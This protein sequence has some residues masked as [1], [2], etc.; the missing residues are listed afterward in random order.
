MSE[1]TLRRSSLS[2]ARITFP[3]NDEGS[4]ENYSIARKKK[5][6]SRYCP[7]KVTIF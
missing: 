5:K 4:R 1:I 6:F 7:L 3:V 2:F